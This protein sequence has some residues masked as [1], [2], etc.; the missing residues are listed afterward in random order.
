M[1]APTTAPA[2]PTAAMVAPTTAPAAPTAAMAAPTT[3]PAAPTAA[4]AAPTKAMMM[5]KPG[6]FPVDPSTVVPAGTALH[7]TQELRI[8]NGH[9]GVAPWRDGGGQRVFS[10]WVY[11][12]LYQIDKFGNVRPYIGVSH[13]VSDNDTIWTF[14][15]R[16]DAV[17]QDGTPVTAADFKAYWEHGAKP[18]NIV[19]WGGGSLTL[20]DIKGW[21]E[22]RAGDITEAEGLTVI[23]DHT[24]QIETSISLPTWPLN[25]AAWHT[26]ISKLDQVL[27][28]E[29]W[30]TNP[31]AAGPY[32]WTTNPDTKIYV[33]EA[34]AADFWGPSPTIKKLHGLNVTDSQVQVIMFENGELDLMTID[35]PTY[36]AALNPEHPFNP[37]LYLAPGGGLW[38]IKMKLDMA[39][40][41]DLLV[42]KSLGHGADMKSIVKAVWGQTEDQ[43][44]GLISPQIPCH[45]PDSTGLQYDP[46]LARQ[47]LSTSTYGGPD[48]LPTLLVDLARPLMVN[49]GVAVKEYWKDNLG[50]ELDILKRESGMPR[51]EGSQF[52]RISLGS[53]IPDPVQI[54]S[55]LTRKDSIEALSNI[56]GGYPVMDALVEYARSL[57]LDHPDRC[58]AFQAVEEEYLD[59]VYMIPMWEVQGVK[60]L[61]QPWLIG[62]ESTSNLDFNTMTTAYIAKH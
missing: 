51:R 56:P 22:V 3:A 12:T 40:L 1:V 13:T 55:N 29:E 57:P 8:P 46:E 36:E 32:K 14:K 37:L 48:N 17:F 41:E 47:A 4:M 31:I 34:D 58:K 25:M 24:L 10:M 43:A 28:D 53:W 45:N 44:T 35:P 27:S 21:E 33:A 50:V 49:M 7:D 54:V 20:G 11:G 42:R 59:K 23:D 2:A 6:V 9:G 5:D 39:P 15:L 60:W 38:F 62:F 52:Y 26:G 61:V 19:A 16:E 18:E 30:F